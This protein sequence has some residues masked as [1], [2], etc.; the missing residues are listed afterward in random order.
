MQL[1]NV[2]K[3]FRSLTTVYEMLADRGYA[4]AWNCRKYTTLEEFRA[5]C[6]LGGHI[7]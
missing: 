2:E 7:Q 4:I 1:T 3:A 5:S 6:T